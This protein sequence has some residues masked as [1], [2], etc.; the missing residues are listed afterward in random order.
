[1]VFIEQFAHA[2]GFVQWVQLLLGNLFELF[3]EIDDVIVL[4]LARVIC[5]QFDLFQLF[6]GVNLVFASRAP[7]RITHVG[8]EIVDNYRTGDIIMMMLFIM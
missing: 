7:Y 1:M 3:N 5:V 4:V 2:G 8:S 6:N